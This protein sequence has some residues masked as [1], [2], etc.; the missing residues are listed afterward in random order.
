MKILQFLIFSLL[1]AV[2]T[3]QTGCVSDP[4]AKI[5]CQNGGNCESG[6]CKCPA[7]YYGTNC[8]KGEV[9]RISAIGLQFGTDPVISIAYSYDAMGKLTTDSDGD[10]TTVYTYST[11][12]LEVQ[13]TYNS[14][15]D[16]EKAKY[17]LNAKGF[18]STAYTENRYSGSIDRDTTQYIYDANGYNIGETKSNY[19]KT[20]TIANGNKVSEIQTGNNSFTGTTEYYLDKIR[21]NTYD[22][23]YAPQY[24]VNNKNM[25]KKYT[26]NYTDGRKRITTY[27]HDYD[28]KGN[29]TKEVIVTTNY[30]TTGG[31]SDSSTDT[32]TYTIACVQL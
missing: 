16:Y 14:S 1:F 7:G 31:I 13:S 24:G 10:K 9:C 23:G 4:C 29:V 12:Q 19:T 20:I 8:E 15:A 30:N 5:S 11:G 22:T 28:A 18:P 32:Y 17:T 3:T 25:H 2:I 27:T 21:P 26:K 6:T